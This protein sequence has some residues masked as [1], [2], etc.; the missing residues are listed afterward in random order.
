MC[1][2]PVW[3]PG[4]V[5]VLQHMSCLTSISMHVVS[6]ASC[7]NLHPTLMISEVMY[8]ASHE[9]FCTVAVCLHLACSS[10][11]PGTISLLYAEYCQGNSDTAR[12]DIPCWSRLCVPSMRLR[13]VCR[14]TADTHEARFET[15]AQQA[16]AVH[17][18][19]ALGAWPCRHDA[20]ATCQSSLCSG[21]LLFPL[22][23][24]NIS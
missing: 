3:Y 22:D 19:Q 8:R 11:I 17:S 4:T 16:A 5:P 20:D 13:T 15:Q 14:K 9:W 10:P 12:A 24:G 2:T 23:L 18:Y 21:R 6:A 1:H 7:Y